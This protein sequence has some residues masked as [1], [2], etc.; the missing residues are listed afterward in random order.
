LRRETLARQRA[1]ANDLM[2]YMFTHIDTDINLDEQAMRLGFDRVYLHK[3]FKRIFGRNIYES[4]KAIRMQKAASLLLTNRISTISEIASA[5]GYA[6][7]T[8]FIRAFKARFGMTPSR[9]RN[10]GYRIYG[11]RIAQ[12]CPARRCKDDDYFET[13]D[14]EICKRPRIRAYYLRH[15]GYDERIKGV[16]QKLHTWALTNN[17]EK[18]E[19][20]SL[21]HDNPAVTPLASC[22]Y[23]AC[24]VT[25]D[26]PLHDDGR[27][28]QFEIAEGVYA[29]FSLQGCRGDLLSFMQWL[30]LTWLPRE[31]Y[32]TTTAPPY[33][34][35]RRNHHL[36]KEGNFDIDFYVAVRF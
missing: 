8:S 33:A 35:Y 4:I 12:A 16:W 6:S 26:T 30:Y 29:K 1:V 19:M 14:Y 21:F 31:G 11:E 18:Y 27:I 13:L 32:E 10:G 23:V 28:P 34:I 17:I 15:Q 3:I 36:D 20:I 24:L 9:W 7:Q 25:E 22:H 2:F 5:C